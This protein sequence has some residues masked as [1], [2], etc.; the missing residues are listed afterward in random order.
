MSHA[1]WSAVHTLA[2]AVLAGAFT[3]DA[4][5]AQAVAPSPPTRTYEVIVGAESVDKLQVVRFGPDGARVSRERVIGRNAVDPDG[6]HGVG[7][8]PDGRT[9]FVSTAHGVPNGTLWKLD[10]ESD[11]VLG[12]VDLGAFPATLQVSADGEFAW[13]VNFNLHGE[14]VPSSVSVVGTRDMV[15]LTRVPTCTMPHGS[16]LSPD[17]THHWSVCMMDDVLVDIDAGRFE[18]ARL[19]GQGERDGH[20]RATAAARRG[21]V[22]RSRRARH[23]AAQAW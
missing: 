8:S 23:G 14:M 15:E 17:G 10:T 3:A 11:R 1:G 5:A 16:R 22:G 7:V 13:V 21:H 19:A 2:A 6:P 20:E 9:Y 18:V 4:M 12:Q